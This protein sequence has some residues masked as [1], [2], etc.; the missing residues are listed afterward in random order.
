MEEALATEPDKEDRRV[1]NKIATATS[2]IA[3]ANSSATTAKA[4]GTKTSTI[5]LPLNSDHAT[6][7]KLGS[8][9]WRIPPSQ[10]I[11]AATT[12]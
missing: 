1:A 5:A 7:R 2:M 3:K 12:L 11:I 9:V 6:Q 8:V 10:R 4:M